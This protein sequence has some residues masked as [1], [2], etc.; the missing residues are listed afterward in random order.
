MA[1]VVKLY[2]QAIRQFFCK[3]IAVN[4]IEKNNIWRESP[5][6]KQ[7]RLEASRGQGPIADGP[8]Q[9]QRPAQLLEFM[10][11]PLMV[12]QKNKLIDHGAGCVN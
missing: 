3:Q 5:D 10:E 12:G 8:R 9:E 7:Y 4:R 1:A 11:N 6:L 2:I